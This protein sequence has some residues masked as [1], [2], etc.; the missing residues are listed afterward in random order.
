MKNEMTF[1][2]SRTKSAQSS[3]MEKVW[4]L[5]SQITYKFSYS[6]HHFVSLEVNQLSTKHHNTPKIVTNA[7]VYVFAVFICITL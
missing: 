7:V 2:I 6:E 4:H 5:D 3:T 1:F